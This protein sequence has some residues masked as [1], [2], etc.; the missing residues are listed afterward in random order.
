MFFLSRFFLFEREGICMKKIIIIGGGIVG[1]CLAYDLAKYE[2]VEVTVL[3][4][5]GALCDEISAANSAIIHAGYDP[6]D[7]TL[8]ARLNKKGAD[9]YPKLCETLG[10][11]LLVCGALVL[12]T[13]E[14]EMETLKV[15]FDRAKRR[16]I[17]VELLD[18]A[19]LLAVEE[20]IQ[21]QVC[22]GMTVPT[23]AVVTP[24][25]I[26]NALMEEAMLNGVTLCL[27]EEVV[28]IQPNEG[29]YL[30]KTKQH[31]FEADA[32][33][34]A[35]GLGSERI[36]RL[37]EE[38]PLYTVT[39]KRGQYV[40]L[41]KHARTYA[42][43]VM[44]PVPT[45]VGK[46]V[47]CVPTVHG[48]TLIGPN[49]EPSL[50]DTSTTA[51]GLADVKEKIKKTMKNVPFQEVIHSYS[52]LRP[53]GNHNDFFIQPSTKDARIIH[54]GCIDSPGLASAPAI[55]EYVIETFLSAIMKLTKKSTWIPR[56]HPIKV[57][58][59]DEDT[60]AALVR[61]QPAYGHIICRCEQISE[62]EVVDCIHG[63][64]GAR[65]IKEIKKRL[66]PGMGKCQGGYCELEVAKIL[67]RELGIALS[68][69][70]YDKT[71]YFQTSK[72][73]C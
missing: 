36:M 12:A 39:P 44:Y 68:E 27:N 22:G 63:I 59:L 29:A 4:R 40:I 46:G 17:R 72:G 43:Q 15:L 50:F 7:G 58:T 73:E 71:A 37:V 45:A 6:E 25:E 11:E 8:K 34:N 32:I 3:E 69:V 60:R 53:C 19:Q 41:S 42:K 35:A 28:D 31:E 48:N 64:H 14:E 54:L 33:I 18:R 21:D 70:T 49:S 62:Q 52:G 56:K 24:W 55:S 47:L 65:T 26:G 20:N 66:R 30:V 38:T 5:N 57:N 13:N 61:E 67:A 9:R 51:L 2:E 10:V 16:D 23:T 1:C